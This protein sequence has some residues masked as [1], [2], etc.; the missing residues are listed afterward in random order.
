MYYLDGGRRRQSLVYFGKTVSLIRE[1]R[2]GALPNDVVLSMFLTRRSLSKIWSRQNDLRTIL[3]AFCDRVPHCNKSDHVAWN[4]I[5]KSNKTG[6]RQQKI[7]LLPPRP[8]QT[9][10]KRK[11]ILTTL[12][13]EAG[14]APPPLAH[15]APRFG[16]L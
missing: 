9:S 1:C 14:V 12:P 6:A 3:D 2:R 5:C 11:M 13:R 4:Q 7:R 15:N 16:A 8:S 10:S